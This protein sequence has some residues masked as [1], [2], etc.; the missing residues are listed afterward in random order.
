MT[1]ARDII[2]SPSYGLHIFGPPPSPLLFPTVSASTIISQSSPQNLKTI[3]I[4]MSQQKDFDLALHTKWYTKTPPAFPVPSMKALGPCTST[5]SWTWEQDFADT[6]KTLT[7]AVRITD[8]K[9]VT[10]V[11]ITYKASNPSATVTAEQKHYPPPPPLSDADLLQA[12]TLYGSNIASWAEA[13]IGTTVGDGECWTLVQTALLDLASTYSKHG[14]EP[15]LLSQGRSHGY[16]ILTLLAPDEGTPADANA[17]LL[18]LAD[19]RRGDVIEL[20]NAHFQSITE[21]APLPRK[22]K[23]K[24]YGKWVK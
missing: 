10:K 21:P 1:P 3:I 4:A 9:S 19:V 15:P 2:S 8:T 12:S 11:R 20:S 23:G 5:Y 7:C 24:E 18:A 16:P 13:T 17:G 22:E 6:T 14:L